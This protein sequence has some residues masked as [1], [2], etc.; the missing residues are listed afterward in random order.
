MNETDQMDELINNLSDLLTKMKDD[1][2]IKE[3]LNKY[4]NNTD[5]DDCVDLFI[6]TLKACVCNQEESEEKE[7]SYE[8]EEVD[9]SCLEID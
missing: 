4:S 3:I 6:N 1:G 9:K 7:S 5:D 2:E 8:D